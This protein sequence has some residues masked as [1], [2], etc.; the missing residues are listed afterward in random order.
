V[1]FRFGIADT[2]DYVRLAPR[3]E[4]RSETNLLA[5]LPWRRRLRTVLP[6]AVARGRPLAT[7]THLALMPA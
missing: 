4:H 6:A 5:P 1:R 2:R 7:V 3:L